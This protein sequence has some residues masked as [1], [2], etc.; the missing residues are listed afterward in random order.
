MDG[1]HDASQHAEKA[2]CSTARALDRFCRFRHRLVIAVL[3]FLV[4]AASSSTRL[5]AQRSNLLLFDPSAIAF[6]DIDQLDSF[7]GAN[8]SPT[9]RWVGHLLEDSGILAE[10]VYYG[11]VFTNTRGGI[12]TDSATRYHGLLELPVA[13]DF[14]KMQVPV[15][16]E[17]FL[18]GQNTHGRGLSEDFVGDTLVLSDIDAF[19]NV[20]Q[21]G[22][23]WW[24]WGLLDGD[25]TVRL[26]KQDVNTEFVFME[27][28]VDFIQSSFELTPSAGLP[29]YPLQSMAGVVL[30]Q[31]RE[32]L[33]L[34]LGVWDAFAKK[35]SWGI[36]N[37]EVVLLIG[38]L[39]YKYALLD[40]TLP[41]TLSLGA[42]YLSEGIV[43]GN[44]LSA[45]HGYAVQ[46]EQQVYRECLDDT[47][48]SQGLA[49]FGAYYPR[50]AGQFVLMDSIGDSAAAGLIYTG[51][52][53]Q[54]DE[55][56]L[57]AGVAWAELYQG[58][59]NQETVVEVFYKAQITPF[60]SV[61]PD[62]QYIASPSGIHRDALVAGVRFEARL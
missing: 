15:P 32:S 18:L 45:T 60:L 29:S 10:P 4:S 57:G 59:T 31:L 12:S 6:D 41:G 48:H 28:A 56:V 19:G 8:N 26:G 33:Q 40:G 30:V 14:E 17:F 7:S 11:E 52:I 53:A 36:S 25:V 61:Q 55:D 13:L 20:M 21:V 16:G 43:S 2:W 38:E 50:F 1:E 35:E 44:R 47:D 37:N 3:T 54:R 49:I 42:G 51:L 5:A 34:K 27:S 62:L 23:Y 46:L 39:E 58:G 24:Q 9:S 22:E